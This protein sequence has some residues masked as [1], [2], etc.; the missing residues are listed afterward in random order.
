MGRL[1]PLTILTSSE[2]L[3]RALVRYNTTSELRLMIDTRTRREAFKRDEILNTGWAR[4]KNNITHGLKTIPRCESLEAI[5]KRKR[6][7]L[8]IEQWIEL[9][10]PI[11]NKEYG[12]YEDE[13]VS[14]H[15]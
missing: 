8:C 13:P 15:K 12:N 9:A 1:L 5:I 10:D 7:S 4:T 14:H 6:T 2:S 3:F 11:K